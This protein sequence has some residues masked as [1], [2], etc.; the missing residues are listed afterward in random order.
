MTNVDG[1]REALQFYADEENY[2]GHDCPDVLIDRGNTARKALASTP[3]PV[4]TEDHGELIDAVAN[5]HVGARLLET[6]ALALLKL[7]GMDPNE[8]DD[9]LTSQREEAGQP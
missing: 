7:L 6:E 9:L 1:L 5:A 4:G 3:A 8:A 2:A